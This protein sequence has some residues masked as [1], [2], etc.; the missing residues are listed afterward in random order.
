VTL[1]APLPT[2]GAVPALNDAAFA[3]RLAHIQSLRA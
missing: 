3:A 2:A 1:E